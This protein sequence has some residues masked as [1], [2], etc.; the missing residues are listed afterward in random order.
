MNRVI[1]S[2]VH[3]SFPLERTLPATSI[4]RCARVGSGCQT[5]ALGLGRVQR[6]RKRDTAWGWSRCP[7]GRARPAPTEKKRRDRGPPRFGEWRSPGAGPT[8]VPPSSPSLSHFWE[9][10]EKLPDKPPAGKFPIDFCLWSPRVLT[11]TM[12]PKQCM[13]KD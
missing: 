13:S 10:L 8:P 4:L 6:C 11:N 12:F 7:R 5:R 9:L 3:L 2:Y 1:A